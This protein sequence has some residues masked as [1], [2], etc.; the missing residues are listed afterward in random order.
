MTRCRILQRYWA[1]CQ[2]RSFQR[3]GQSSRWMFSR[4][5]SAAS[6]RDFAGDLR[7]FGYTITTLSATVPRSSPEGMNIHALIV[8]VIIVVVVVVV[9]VVIISLCLVYSFRRHNP[10]VVLF[11]TRTGFTWY[12]AKR[13]TANGTT[14]WCWRGGP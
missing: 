2:S 8:I 5:T 13:T 6:R 12:W 7:R 11:Y 10:V 1:K 14:D 9:V 4:C 3:T